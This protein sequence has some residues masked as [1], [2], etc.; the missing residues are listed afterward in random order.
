MNRMVNVKFRPVCE[1]GH[2]FKEFIL[3]KREEARDKIDRNS[4]IMKTTIDT[5]HPRYCPKCGG[6]VVGVE[7]PNVMTRSCI[8]YEEENTESVL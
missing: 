7:F 3:W 4:G 2:A 6:K 1:C 8:E 5:I